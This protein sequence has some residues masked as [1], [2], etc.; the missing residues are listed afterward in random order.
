MNKL[1]PET[2]LVQLG[3]IDDLYLTEAETLNIAVE[4][5]EKRKKAAKYGAYGVAGLMLLAGAATAYWKFRSNESVQLE[6]QVHSS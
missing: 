5:T 2:L 3:G 6:P 4:K 1:N